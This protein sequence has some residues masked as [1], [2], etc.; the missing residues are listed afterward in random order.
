MVRKNTLP[1][2]PPQPRPPL[3][4]GGRAMGEGTGVRFRAGAAPVGTAPPP[5][6][7]APSFIYDLS[8]ERRAHAPDLPPCRPDR[9]A[10]RGSRPERFCPSPGDDAVQPGAGRRRPAHRHPALRSRV[11]RSLRPALRRLLP[12]RLRP[13]AGGGEPPPAPPAP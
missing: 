6:A 12:V 2:P 3:P 9:R 10:P 8:P 13:V 5:L 4:D 11:R 7:P 1:A